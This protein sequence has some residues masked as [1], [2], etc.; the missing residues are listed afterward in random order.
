MKVK[1]INRTK[2]HT[3]DLHDL[4]VAGLWEYGPQ[5]TQRDYQITVTYARKC[6][7]TGYAYYPSKID[8]RRPGLII[9]RLPKPEYLK[10]KELAQVLIHEIGH[11]CGA[12]HRQMQHWWKITTEFEIGRVIRVKEVTTKKE[13]PIGDKLTHIDTHI[14]KLRIKIKRLTTL[15]KKWERKHKYYEKKAASTPAPTT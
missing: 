2:Y 15:L 8:P 14:T 3:K 13:K 4:F 9:M 7:V 10:M 1:V 5:A 11:T 6:R 12:H